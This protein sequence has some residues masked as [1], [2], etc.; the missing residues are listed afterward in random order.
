MAV[1]EECNLGIRTEPDLSLDIQRMRSELIETTKEMKKNQKEM[2]QRLESKF[3]NNKNSLDEISDRLQSFGAFIPKI[4]KSNG[5]PG[6]SEKKFK[7]KHV[8]KN[9]NEF[10]ENEQNFS[11]K[12]EHFNANWCIMTARFDD[13]LGLYVFCEPNDPSDKWSIR[14]KSEY[15]VFDKNQDVVIRTSEYCY[16]ENQGWGCPR[17]QEW[18]DMKEWF[19]VDGNL[20]VEATVTIIETTGLGKEKIRKFDESQKNISDVILVVKDIKFYVSKMLLAA[21]STVFKALLLGNFKESNQSEVTLHGIDPDDFHNFLE[22]LY[23]EPAIDDNTVEGVALLADMY[24]APNVIR[25]CE[26]FLLEKSKKALEK[27]LEIASRYQLKKLEENCISEIKAIENVRS[28]VS[29]DNDHQS[30][31]DFYSKSRD[32]QQ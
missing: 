5:N 11:E 20:T 16:Q 3:E 2:L 4:I 8:F 30:K 15:K 12:E 32:E 27:K 6:K 13:H 19:L 22:V 14:T 1:S 23:G 7:L 28:G 31:F 26:E 21:Q 29:T 24:D 25:K 18:E 9:V 10:K 17:F